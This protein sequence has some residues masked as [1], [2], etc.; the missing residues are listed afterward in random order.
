MITKYWCDWCEDMVTHYM[1]ADDTGHCPCHRV[2]WPPEVECE[3]ECHT[4]D[5]S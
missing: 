2:L 5:D 4:P 1:I 3:C